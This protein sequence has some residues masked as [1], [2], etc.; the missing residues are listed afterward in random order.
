MLILAICKHSDFP[1]INPFCPAL[2][3]L[4]NVIAYHGLLG[5]IGSYMKIN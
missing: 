4:C 3:V 1:Q 2:L 5:L